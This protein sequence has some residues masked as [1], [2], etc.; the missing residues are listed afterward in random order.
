MKYLS[1]T[2]LGMLFRCAHQY[3][4]RYVDG[5]KKAPGIA[6][7]VGRSVDESVNQDLQNV[8]DNGSLLPEEQIKDIA[9]DSLNQEWEKEEP[10]LSK[11]EKE[12]G[13]K[14]VKGECTDK[15]VRLASLHLNKVAPII[16]PKKIQKKWELEVAGFPY[17][18]MGYIDIMEEDSIRDTKTTAAK[19]TGAADKSMQMTLY[20]LAGKKI[21]GKDYKL[22]LDFLVDN[23]I[24][25]EDI[26]PTTRSQKDFEAFFRKLEIV[27]KFLEKG[28]FLPAS[29]EYS[30][31]C[32]E[33]YCGFWDIC[34]YV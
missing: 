14:K 29:R 12:K 17:D 24:P 20:A 3:K 4:L 31:F 9:R 18:L 8:I 33:K 19:K 15:S 6:A 21:Y 34:P 5:I 7:Y 27:A 11:E 28:I 1:S 30:W 13:K 22:F 32:C 26:Q 25:K 2:R 16:K 10:L 23:K